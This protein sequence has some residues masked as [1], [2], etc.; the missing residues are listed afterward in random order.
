MLGSGL[1]GLLGA[2]FISD[3]TTARKLISFRKYLFPFPSAGQTLEERDFREKS[4]VLNLAVVDQIHFGTY[5][6]VLFLGYP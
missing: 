2:V 4:T 1:R 6:L 5:N 3:L